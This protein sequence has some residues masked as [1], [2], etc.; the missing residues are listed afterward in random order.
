MIT[1]PC[2]RGLLQLVHEEFCA[3]LA[4]QKAIQRAFLV[5]GEV[6]QTQR[7][8]RCVLLLEQRAVAAVKRKPGRC[9]PKLGAEMS[10]HLRR[11]HLHGIEWRSHDPQKTN[12]QR[13][14]QPV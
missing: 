5:L 3:G 11:N 2:A 7:L 14:A 6:A 13:H 8:F 4:P 10:Q 12:L 9:Y 1:E